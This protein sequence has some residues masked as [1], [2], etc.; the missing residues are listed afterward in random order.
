MALVRIEEAPKWKKILG[1]VGPGLLVSV[2][3]LD[4]GNL[5]TDLQA[6]ADH[7]F[8]L[9]WIVLVGLI[10][11][12]IIQ[13][14]SANLGAVTGKHLSEHCKA[15]YPTAVNYCLWILAEVAVIAADIPEVMGTAFALNILFHFPIWVGV[16]LAGLNT[17]LLLAVQRYGIRKL[18]V[19]IVILLLVL[20]GCFFAEMARARPDMVEIAK[21][22]FIPKLDGNGAAQDAIALLGALVMPHNLYLHSALVISRK[23]PHSHRGINDACKYFLVESGFA[24]FVAFLINVAVVSVSGS[25]C[26]NRNVSSPM[27]TRCED[28]TLSSSASLLKDTLGSWSSKVY[29]VSLLASGQSSAVTGTYAGQYIM[30]G[31]LDLKMKPWS[32][33]LLTRCIAI[34]PSLII[35]LIGGSS[36]AGKLIIISSM[37]LAFEL[38][39]ALIPLLKFTSSSTK[40]GQHKNSVPVTMISWLLGCCL[41][42]INLYFIST[43]FIGWFTRGRLSKVGSILTAVVLFPTMMLYMAMVVYLTLRSETPS[44]SPDTM[45]SDQIPSETKVDNGERDVEMDEH[46][47]CTEG[48]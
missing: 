42:V 46:I 6:G 11:A 5:Q 25:I 15:G 20:G 1:Y 22:M 7:E 4:P 27:S 45:V 47:V 9:L 38:P 44:S 37:I 14:R 10:F 48:N 39:F 16:L 8:Q 23:I 36:G 29:A 18:E 32:R 31:F 24:L 34:M 12:L 2:A 21:G 33:N 30:Q 19:V 28:V 35:S 41:I 3:Y 13:S 26:Y 40:M 43:S 17:L